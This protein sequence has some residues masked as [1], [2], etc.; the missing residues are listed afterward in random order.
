MVYVLDQDLETRRCLTAH[1]GAIGVE[2]WPFGS[3]SEF[4]EIL[5]HLMPACIL[6]DMDMPQMRGL[7]MMDELRRRGVDWPVVAISVRDELSLAVEAMK[8]GAVDFLLKPVTEAALA[9]ALMP[10]LAAL[11]RLVEAGE[12]RRAAQERVG[13]LTPREIDIALALLSGQAN[14]TVAH[15][16]GISVRT[17][18]MH[19]AHIMAKLGVKSLAEAALL[20]TQA[21]LTVTSPSLP[22]PSE[23]VRPLSRLV[24]SSSPPPPFLLRRL[25]SRSA[26]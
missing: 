7:D 15:E 1:L 25:A 26:V 19:R 13:R 11:D 22:R 23:A 4:L 2:A 18:E 16:L 10:A 17:V 3:G 12:S 9:A 5:G 21:G 24:P 6:L 20:A 8:R 14:K